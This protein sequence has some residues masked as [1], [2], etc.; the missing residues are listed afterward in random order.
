VPDGDVCAPV[1][2]FRAG[3]GVAVGVACAGDDFVTVLGVGDG[4]GGAT[5]RVRDGDI[6]DGSTD[7][8]FEFCASANV[9]ETKTIQAATTDFFIF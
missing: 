1:A 4:F 5:L 6:V 2:S 3:R 8:E 7:D 9:A